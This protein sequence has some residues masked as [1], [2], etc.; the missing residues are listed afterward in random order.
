MIA[1]ALEFEF[2]NDALLHQT[3]KI[4]RSGNAIPRPNLFGDRASSDQFALFEHQNFTTGPRQI[5]STNQPIVPAA[6]D[7]DIELFQVPIVPL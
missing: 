3:G 4:R 1:K 5:G 7:D 2:P 6:D